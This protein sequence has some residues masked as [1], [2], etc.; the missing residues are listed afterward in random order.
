MVS[1]LFSIVYSFLI[2]C[3]LAIQIQMCKE[4][5]K[6]IYIYVQVHTGMFLH[7]IYLHIQREPWLFFKI[8]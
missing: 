3:L 1:V 8:N 7:R 2:L 6:Y 5:Y 4:M